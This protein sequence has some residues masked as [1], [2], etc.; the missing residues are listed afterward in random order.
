MLSTVGVGAR[1]TYIP[2]LPQCL[3][4]PLLELGPPPHSPQAN[5]PLPTE[6]KRGHTRLSLGMGGG[7]GSQFQRREKQL[8]HSVYSLSRGSCSRHQCLFYG[9]SQTVDR[10]L[11]SSVVQRS[12]DSKSL[13]FQIYVQYITGTV[14]HIPRNV[15]GV[16]SVT[17]LAHSRFV[18]QSPL[19]FCVGFS[20]LIQAR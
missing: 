4:P 8:Q 11:Y 2:R 20:F 18:G 6:P 7:G 3:S 19:L 9:L 13:M 5:V 15:S 14:H 12:R 17:C 16:L 1:S 10:L